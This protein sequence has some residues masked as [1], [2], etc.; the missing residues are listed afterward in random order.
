MYGYWLLYVIVIINVWCLFDLQC[1][2][3][4]LWCQWGWG[5]H[6]PPCNKDQQHSCTIFLTDHNIPNKCNHVISIVDFI[7]YK[8]FLIRFQAKL[9]IYVHNNVYIWIYR[10]FVCLMIVFFLSNF[11]FLKV[12]NVYIHSW[13]WF[14]IK[15][16]MFSNII[17]VIHINIHT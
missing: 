11:K 1:V 13:W 5:H 7:I 16:K 6:R 15:K 14:Y 17:V 8:S 12:M 10:L 4:G 3:I 9:V 2:D